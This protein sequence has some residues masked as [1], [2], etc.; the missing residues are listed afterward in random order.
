MLIPVYNN[1]FKKDLAKMVRSNKDITKLITVISMLINNIPLPDKYKD[2][3]LI[4]NYKDHQECHIEPN[5]LLIYMV[6]GQYIEFVRTG[7]HSDLFK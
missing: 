1:V 3:K 6:S 7:S 5:W 2:H 4:G